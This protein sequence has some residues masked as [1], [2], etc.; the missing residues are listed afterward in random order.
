[1]PEI[2][3][4]SPDMRGSSDRQPEPSTSDQYV[5]GEHVE[6]GTISSPRYEGNRRQLKK[7]FNLLS[8]AG[9]G[10]VTGNVWPALGGSLLSSIP[11]GG[12]PGVIYEFLA[13][14]FCYFTVAV[15]LAEFSS[16]LP[17]SSGVLLWASVTGGRRYGRMISYFAGYW[18]CLAWVFAEASVSLI[19]GKR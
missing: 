12:A 13:A 1:M 19:S 6:C 3:P 10:L 15:V 18:N 9:V 7:S 14:S 5:L 8:L 16:A 17:S 11:N 4:K 2:V